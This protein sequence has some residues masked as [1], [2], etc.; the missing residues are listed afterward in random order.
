MALSQQKRVAVPYIDAET[1]NMNMSEINKIE[2]NFSIG[3]FGIR[4]PKIIKKFYKSDLD[5]II[6]PGVAF[7][8]KGNRIGFGRGYYDKFLKDIQGEIPIIGIAFDLQITKEYIPVSYTD[9]PMDIIITET[10]MI[11]TEH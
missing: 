11:E 4:E 9:V 5:L 1:D 3:K 6:C 8:T 10:R 7:D 2:D